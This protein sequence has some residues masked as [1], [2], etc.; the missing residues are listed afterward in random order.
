[1]LLNYYPIR[2]FK[3]LKRIDS[4]WIDIGCFGAVRPLKNQLIQA[5]AAMGYANYEGKLLRFHMN[6]GR[7]ERGDEEMKTIRALF[8]GTEH[9]LVEHPWLAHDKFLELVRKMDVGLQVS[10][11]ESYNIVAADFVTCGVPIVGSP[12]IEWLNRMYTANPNSS[13]DI[14]TAIK[15]VLF[16]DEIGSNWFNLHNLKEMNHASEKTWLEYLNY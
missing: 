9:E 8:K 13:A 15:R 4:E 16:L 10:L 1:V 2:S 6:V 14:R 3:P 7:V 5:M 12:D 11:S